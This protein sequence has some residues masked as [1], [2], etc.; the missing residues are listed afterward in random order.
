MG[1]K[2]LS[3][4]RR[5]QV[6]QNDR[7]RLS[8][9]HLS[10]LGSQM[11]F[12][13]ATRIDTVVDWDAVRKKYRDLMAENSENKPTQ[14]DAKEVNNEANLLATLEQPSSSTAQLFGQ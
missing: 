5:T 4:V 10:P 2:W 14:E 9:A 3:K 11:S 1:Q 8:V 12:S 13:N 6:T 7:M